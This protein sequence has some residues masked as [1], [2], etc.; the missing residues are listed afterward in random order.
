[1]NCCGN[2]GK[3][4]PDGASYCNGCG[5]KV[6]TKNT[7]RK[8][9]YDGVIH[10]CPSC[11]EILKS[12]ASHCTS[13]G[14]EIRENDVCSSLQDFQLRLQQLEN[15]MS[16]GYKYRYISGENSPE[17]KILKQKITL[18]STYPIPNNKE[19]ITEFMILA[20]SKFDP[21]YYATHLYE[22]DVSDAW[23][24]KVEQ[25]YQKAKLSFGDTNDFE[26]IQRMYDKIYA[27]V[28]N[29]K[30]EV[31]RNIREIEE[32]ENKA[33]RAIRNSNRKPLIIGLC[34]LFIPL[35]IAIGAFVVMS[36][37]GEPDADPNAIKI[38][39][40]SEEIEGQ[41]Y[42]D[43]V[44]LLEKT[45]FTNVEAREDSWSLIHKSDTVKKVSIDGKEEF[46]SYSKFSKDAKVI[47]FYYK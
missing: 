25:C 41:Y 5:A 45:G 3:V 29:S 2:C 26:N 44:E 40:S 6:L 11:G 37:V 20:A 38:G 8:F 22:E 14:F 16:G 42:Q 17:N 31:Q 27:T 13:C 43:V 33:Q 15:K 1:M 32:R 47:I 46:Y 23:L 12:F 7:E 18:I 35:L 9:V 36:V 19:D 28:E 10:K 4:L 34:M 39:I 30:R 24:S 21:L